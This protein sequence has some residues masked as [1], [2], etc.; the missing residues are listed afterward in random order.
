MSNNNNREIRS[1][2]RKG[3]T[4]SNRRLSK[5]KAK[6]KTKTREQKNQTTETNELTKCNYILIASMTRLRNEKCVCV[7]FFFA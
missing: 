6:T 7:C 1:H 3:P 5:K 4:A 2:P